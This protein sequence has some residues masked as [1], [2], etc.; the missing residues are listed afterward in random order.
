[1]DQWRHYC[2]TNN[3]CCVCD[4]SCTDAIGESGCGDN[5][6]VGLC[7]GCGTCLNP[8]LMHI[9]YIVNVGIAKNT[10]N[11]TASITNHCDIIHGDCADIIKSVRVLYGAG[12]V[13]QG[14][15]TRYFHYINKRRYWW[16]VRTSTT[17]T[18]RRNVVIRNSTGLDIT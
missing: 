3:H 9:K 2:N 17:S 5:I 6:C 8:C 14:Q 4:V 16:S 12:S 13:W 7:K 18:A 11:W 1:M 10:N 15:R